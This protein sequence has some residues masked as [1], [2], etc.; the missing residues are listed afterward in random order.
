MQRDLGDT[1]RGV[2]GTYMYETQTMVVFAVN[3]LGGRR[4]HHIYWYKTYCDKNYA[5]FLPC[6]IFIHVECIKEFREID[7]VLS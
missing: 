1:G 4:Y 2:R 6:Y 3:D 7:R 5:H